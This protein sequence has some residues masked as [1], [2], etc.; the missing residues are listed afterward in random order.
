[1]LQSRKTRTKLAK[2]IAAALAGGSLLGACEI[3]LHNAIVDG[4]K[5]YVFTL[6]DPSLYDGL[7][8]DLFDTTG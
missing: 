1:M 3:R 7:F 5:G 8:D 6:F 4:T 2:T